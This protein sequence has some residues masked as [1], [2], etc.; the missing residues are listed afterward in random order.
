MID[1]CLKGLVDLVLRPE[2]FFAR[3][4]AAPKRRLT[5]AMAIV[6][7]FGAALDRFDILAYRQGLVQTTLAG[8]ASIEPLLSSWTLYWGAALLAAIVGAPVLYF[9]GG[10]WVW[11]RAAFAGAPQPDAHCARALFTYSTLIWAAPAIVS[12]AVST[13]LHE[14]FAAALRAPE[15][16]GTISLVALP[17][18]SIFVSYRGAVT[19][20]P[21]K[22]GRMRFWFAVLPAIVAI[23][24][25]T[26]MLAA[27]VRVMLQASR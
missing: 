23:G 7:A 18:W 10:L 1:R 27:P 19:M 3:Y 25:T 20:F 14:D 24:A 16:W 15:H 22:P 13:L 17:F 8:S 4:A 9:L 2:V 11:A 5:V 26:V 21:G 12:A 6:G